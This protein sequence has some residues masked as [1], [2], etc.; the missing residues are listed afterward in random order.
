[1]CIRILQKDG[2]TFLE[3][4]YD[5]DYIVTEDLGF[6]IDG[7]EPMF[8]PSQH[9]QSNADRFVNEL[10]LYSIVMTGIGDILFSGEG[11]NEAARVCGAVKE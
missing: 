1:M 11:L 9:P 10:D 4:T 8:P 5:S 2:Q 6:I 7:P 3:V